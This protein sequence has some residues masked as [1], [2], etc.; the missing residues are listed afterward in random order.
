MP[1]MQNDVIEMLG[2]RRTKNDGNAFQ[3]RSFDFV[4]LHT[5]PGDGVRKYLVDVCTPVMESL[6]PA[7]K[8]GDFPKDMLQEIHDAQLVKLEGGDCGTS[9]QIEEERDT[10]RYYVAEAVREDEATQNT[11]MDIDDI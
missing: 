10:T 2:I 5:V 9:L 1:Q 3:T 7:V 4:Y 11:A 8:K 6:A